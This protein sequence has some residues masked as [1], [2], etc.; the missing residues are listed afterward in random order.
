MKE[1]FTNEMKICTCLGETGCIC[2]TF[3][4]ADLEEGMVVELR[5]GQ[6]WCAY[7]KHI[8]ERFVEGDR[9]TLFLQNWNDDLTHGNYTLRDI[10]SIERKVKYF[11]S[12]YQRPTVE[13]GYWVSDND[14]NWMVEHE[15]IVED[16]FIPCPKPKESE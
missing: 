11:E 1:E 4:K 13:Q 5:C 16:A 3:T 10:V 9:Q 14:R 12:V 15:G 2:D 8:L 6:K 7:S